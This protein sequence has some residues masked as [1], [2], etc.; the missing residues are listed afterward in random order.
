MLPFIC[1]FL[2]ATYM[3]SYLYRVYVSITRLL[4]F[5]IMKGSTPPAVPPVFDVFACEIMICY[6]SLYLSSDEL[7]NSASYLVLSYT[8]DLSRTEYLLVYSSIL[9][10]N[11]DIYCCKLVV[12][13]LQ[14]SNYTWLWFDFD[15]IYFSYHL[16]I[17][18]IANSYFSTLAP[19]SSN[20]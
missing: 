3:L 12:L 19:I 5:S 6:S 8:Q 15:L 16:F 20:L 10:L 4:N 7:T 14:F 18:A 1:L 13:F 2:P 17:F 11:C 9:N